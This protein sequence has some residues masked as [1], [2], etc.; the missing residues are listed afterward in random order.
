M[1]TVIK[2][3]D[4]YFLIPWRAGLT[5]MQENSY[6]DQPYEVFPKE[7]QKLITIREWVTE[8]GSVAGNYMV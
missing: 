3:E 2:Y 7:Y 6:W 8:D 1:F 5:E 4:Q